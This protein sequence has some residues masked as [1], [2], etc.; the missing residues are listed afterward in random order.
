MIHKGLL[1]DNKQISSKDKYTNLQ[2][3]IT[4]IFGPI[5][6]AG[7]RGP[8]LFYIWS[9]LFVIPLLKFGSSPSKTLYILQPLSKSKCSQT[10]NNNKVLKPALLNR[11]G[12]EGRK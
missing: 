8:I 5:N 7:Q 4:K 10:S 1:Y 9:P 2:S 3:M 11:D 12:N 6:H